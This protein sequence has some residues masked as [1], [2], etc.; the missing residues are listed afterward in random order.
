MPSKESSAARLHSKAILCD[1]IE[2]WLLL[3]VKTPCLFIEERI[4]K[5]GVPEGF[6][7]YFLSPA[8]S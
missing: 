1:P 3:K 5:K 8:Y 4:L 6:S 2:H 7:R